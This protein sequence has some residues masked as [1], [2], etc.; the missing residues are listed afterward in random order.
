A[1]VRVLEQDV[2]VGAHDGQAARRQAP[3]GVTPLDVLDLD[4]LGA[5]VGEERR[6]GGDERVLGDLENA[7]TLHDCGHDPSLSSDSMTE[8]LGG[9]HP[10]RPSTSPTP[11]SY[12]YR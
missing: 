12:G 4:D 7:D 8:M 9:A 3:H 2:D 5:P 11:V 6:C 10:R 1:P